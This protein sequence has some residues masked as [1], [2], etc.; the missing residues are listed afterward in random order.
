M[1]NNLKQEYTY[2]KLFNSKIMKFLHKHKNKY[3]KDIINQMRNDIFIK[4]YSNKN[5]LPS[6]E[7]ELDKYIYVTCKNLFYDYNR[8]DKK[9][10]IY[11][12]NNEFLENA[13]TENNI[14]DNFINFEHYNVK[15]NNLSD[16]KKNIIKYKN[17][18]YNITEISKL[19]GISRAET[20]NIYNKIKKNGF[21]QKDRG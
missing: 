2:F 9:N 19:I 5:N 20:Y 1:I 15:I 14:E 3:D 8:K 16:I 17:E 6:V 7:N 21:I 4:L 11:T 13:L 18:G 12:E 10:I